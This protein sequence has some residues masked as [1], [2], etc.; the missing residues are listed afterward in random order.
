MQTKTINVKTTNGIDKRIGLKIAE[1]RISQGMTRKDLA[2]ELGITHQQLQKYEKGVNRITVGR[3]LQISEIMRIPVAYF[4]EDY[5][6]NILPEEIERQRMC[7][8]TMSSFQKIK[9]HKQQEALMQLMKA[10]I[11]E[12]RE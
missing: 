6:S 8:E 5:R 3:I 12:A 11:K 9:N 1:L 7:L 4:F 10:M 2:K